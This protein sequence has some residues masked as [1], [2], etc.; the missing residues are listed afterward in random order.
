MLLVSWEYSI[1]PVYVGTLSARGRGATT[2]P[3]VLVGDCA[4]CFG[5]SNQC[6]TYSDWRVGK[7][8]SH[9]GQLDLVQCVF[10]DLAFVYR[11]LPFASDEPNRGRVVCHVCY[12]W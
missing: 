11:P 1:L 3:L 2:P 12:A 5:E 10:V 6:N 7:F 4:M 8:V 9:R